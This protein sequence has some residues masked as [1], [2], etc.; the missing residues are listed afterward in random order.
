MRKVRVRSHQTLRTLFA[1]S[2]LNQFSSFFFNCEMHI[3]LARWPFGSG[4][5]SGVHAV[6]ASCCLIPS[7]TSPHTVPVPRPGATLHDSA[8]SGP[9]LGGTVWC[10]SFRVRRLS[11]APRPQG[12]PLS[13][14]VSIS[15][16]LMADDTPW[17]H[18]GHGA[19]TAWR[20]TLGVRQLLARAPGTWVCKP[21][22]LGHE[23]EAKP[24]DHPV[25][26]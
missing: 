20:R 13:W 9:R 19:S 14:R 2:W 23:A 24:L 4:Q 16:L 3:N 1:N 11:V 6:T 8:D 17:L 21:R 5:L 12:H 10:S 7:R 18:S 15:F 22:A 26:R 25:T